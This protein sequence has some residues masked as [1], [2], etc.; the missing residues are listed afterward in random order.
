MV[1]QDKLEFKATSTDHSKIAVQGVLTS[2]RKNGEAKKIVGYYLASV[3]QV[4]KISLAIFYEYEGMFSPA[5]H[6]R[7]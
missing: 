1:Y 5:C 4:G 7:A 3:N 6:C 2:M